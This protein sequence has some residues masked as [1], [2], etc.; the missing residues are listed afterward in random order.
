MAIGGAN[1]VRVMSGYWEELGVE[2][3]AEAMWLQWPETPPLG[4]TTGERL[5]QPSFPS[6]AVGEG[7]GEGAG[8]WRHAVVGSALCFC[9][10]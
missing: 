9:T 3:N 5:L 1:V 6:A 2:P 7:E 4:A 8:N 10:F